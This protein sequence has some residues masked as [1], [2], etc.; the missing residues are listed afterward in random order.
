M[1][2][3]FVGFLLV[4]LTL[5]CSM[6]ISA[7]AGEIV[8]NGEGAVAVEPDI[9]YVSLGV[10]VQAATAKEAQAKNAA[11][12]ARV[13]TDL[14]NSGIQAKD[15]QTTNFNLFPEYRSNNDP[16]SEQ[17]TAYRAV[18]QVAVTVR[19]IRKVGEVIDLSIKAGANNINHVIFSV[20]SPEQWRDKAIEAAVKDAR[21]KAEVMAKTAKVA[22]KSILSITESGVNIRPLQM[23]TMLKSVSGYANVN[24][25]VETGDVKV[26]ASVQIKFEI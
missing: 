2:K 3:W 15:I 26:T 16:M 17:I 5:S 6:D 10:N 24:T 19:D 20:S 14:K 9:A 23:D 25:P 8:V 22:L 1:K 11:L 18:N 13:T 12:M 7:V 21:A 4:I